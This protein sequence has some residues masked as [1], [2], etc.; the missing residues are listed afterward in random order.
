MVDDAFKFEADLEKFAKQLDIDIVTVV[1]K[2]SFDIFEGVVRRTPVD[3]GRARASWIMSLDEPSDEVAIEGNR[4][5]DQATQEALAN[6]LPDITNLSQPINVTNNL[7]YIE[8]LEFGSSEQAPTGMV[9]VTLA[10]VEAEL[11]TASGEVS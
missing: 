2:L 3:S 8:P 10:E 4:S 5:E 1:K 6:K 9:R 7:P 11:K